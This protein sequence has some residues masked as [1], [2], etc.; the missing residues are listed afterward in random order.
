MTTADRRQREF[1]AREQCI[2][3]H[4]RAL[5]ADKGFLNL[6]MAELARR[7]EYATGTLYQH[8]A[9]KEDLLF[10]LWAEGLR[11]RQ[12][13]LRRVVDWRAP[14]RQRMGAVGYA[15]WLFVVS[16]PDHFR[17]EQLARAEDVWMRASSDVRDRAMSEGE[18]CAQLAFSIVDD[19]V[20]QG[21]LVL[22]EQTPRQVAFGFWTMSVGTHAMVHTADALQRLDVR[23]PYATLARNYQALLNALDWQPLADPTDTAAL[24]DF[25]DQLHADVFADLP[26]PHTPSPT[27]EAAAPS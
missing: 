19:A 14:S 15:D 7:S 26:A 10:L 13:L 25:F 27:E 8:V 23:H 21:D 20:N 18:R 16:H 4:A 5:I 22:V 11:V 3:E 17:L 9:C 2:L 6:Q 24:N 12:G 1:A